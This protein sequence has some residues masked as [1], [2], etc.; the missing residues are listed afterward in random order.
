MCLFSILVVFEGETDFSVNLIFIIE[1]VWCRQLVPQHTLLNKWFSPECPSYSSRVSVVLENV[2]GDNRRN[3]HSCARLG[4]GAR[5]ARRRAQHVF[6]HGACQA[7]LGCDL[8]HVAN[9]AVVFSCLE[10]SMVLPTVCDFL[11]Y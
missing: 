10:S 8:F 4:A 3:A 1:K 9:P 5:G 2:I 11:R 6:D 7:S